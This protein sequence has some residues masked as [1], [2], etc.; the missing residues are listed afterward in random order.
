MDS[1]PTFTIRNVAEPRT[2]VTKWEQEINKKVQRKKAFSKDRAAK[3]QEVFLNLNEWQM[4][5]YGN[6]TSSFL[7]LNSDY[8]Y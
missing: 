2:F 3:Y 8:D 1:H 5:R 7:P 4:V 6:F